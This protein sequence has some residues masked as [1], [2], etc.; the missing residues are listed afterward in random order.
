M[1][2]GTTPGFSF[3]PRLDIDQFIQS[4]SHFNP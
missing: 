3:L 1:F 2:S 4:I